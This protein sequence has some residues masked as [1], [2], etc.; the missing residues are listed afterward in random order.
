MNWRGSTRYYDSNKVSV[1][2]HALM[3]FIYTFRT[4]QRSCF[5]TSITIIYINR[6]LFDKGYH[7][8]WLFFNLFYFCQKRIINSVYS[9]RYV[10]MIF[11][12]K[13]DMR[14]ISSYSNKWTYICQLD[15][16]SNR[17]IFVWTVKNGSRWFRLIMLHCV[18]L[19]LHFIVS[20]FLTASVKNV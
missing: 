13:N 5:C 3:L 9:L 15:Y 16:L 10:V 19:F 4:W 6:F 18:V 12:V 20:A 7:Q 11:H 2:K 8:Y 14:L 17:L 1:F